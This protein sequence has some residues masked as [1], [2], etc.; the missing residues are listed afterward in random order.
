MCPH[1]VFAELEMYIRVRSQKALYKLCLRSQER[2]VKIVIVVEQLE[3]GI[4]E[5]S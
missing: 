1:P 5:L 4:L 3:L 2:C